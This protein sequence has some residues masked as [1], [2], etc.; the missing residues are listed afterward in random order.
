MER[1]QRLSAEQRDSLVAYLDGELEEGE[2]RQ[3]D[4]VL[5]R[6][7]VARHEVEA[8]ARTWELLDL[9][10]QPNATENFTQRT[11][12]TL[13]AAEQRTNLT[14]EP[15]FAYVRKG[16]VGMVWVSVLVASAVL[17]YAVTTKGVPNL[18]DDLI[19]DISLYRNL[20]LYLAADNLDFVTELERTADFTSGKLARRLEAPTSATP[21]ESYQQAVDLTVSERNLVL[22][23]QERWKALPQARQEELRVFHAQI[24]A[25]PP[26]TRSTL[27]TYFA[28]LQ[29][30]NL[31]QQEDLRTA[32]TTANRLDFVR[33]FKETQDN[34]RETQMFEINVDLQKF[35]PRLPPWPYLMAGDVQQVVDVLKEKTAAGYRLETERA[36]I[37]LVEKH[38]RFVRYSVERRGGL[39]K[40]PEEAELEELIEA[41]GDENVRRALNRE[42]ARNDPMLRRTLFRSF[43]V[44]GLLAMLSEELG[45][46]LPTEAKLRETFIKQTGEA[47]IELLQLSPEELTLQLVKMVDDPEFHR[48]SRLRQEMGSLFP[49]PPGG[50]DGRRPWMMMDRMRQLIPPP[51]RKDGPPRPREERRSGERRPGDA[52]G[53]GDRPPPRPS[54]PPAPF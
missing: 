52:P 35:K 51:D 16:A 11:L 5:S 3:I 49:F 27:E 39:A 17:G 20:D 32:A 24:Q 23:N 8:L 2:T 54:L 10:P 46:H 47:R 15:W 13:K 19:R 53:P 7:E 42:E 37:T 29:T 1:V 33:R 9:L 28:W 41:I 6:S 14:E 30:L 44:K 38:L 43:L 21:Q 31:G 22:R 50:G 40:W 45:K 36:P 48:L 4:S 18:Q 26:A 25:A 34:E 12:T